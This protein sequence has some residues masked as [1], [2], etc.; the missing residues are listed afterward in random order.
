MKFEQKHNVK[1]NLYNAS[2]QV[3]FFFFNVRQSRVLTETIDS[4]L[5]SEQDADP[6]GEHAGPLGSYG[7]TTAVEQLVDASVTRVKPSHILEN[8]HVRTMDL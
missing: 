5:L 6:L 2:K 7:H 8:I 1:E 3:L 4:R